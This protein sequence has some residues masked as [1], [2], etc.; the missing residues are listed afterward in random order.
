M[1]TLAFTFS[2]SVLY[3]VS[4]SGD[5]LNPKFNSKGKI[6]LPTNHSI[7]EKVIWF[8][9]QIEMILNDVNPEKIAYKLTVSNVTNAMVQ[10]SY[11]G[12]AILNL[13]ASKKKIDINHIAPT[14]IVTSKFNLP[15]GSNLHDF[16][17][18][19]IG[20]HAPHWDA[21]MKDTALMALIL[22]K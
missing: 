10:N 17:D 20:T 11:Y 22:L 1:T 9:N 13:L 5:N 3:Y 21:K 7:S 8:E 12:Q 19:Q 2:T 6:N 15:K 16:L 14:S 18:A 4:L